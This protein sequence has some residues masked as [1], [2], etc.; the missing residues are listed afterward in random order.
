VPLHGSIPFEEQTRALRPADRRKVILATNIAETSL[1][2]EGVR[3]VIDSGRAR[4][5]GYDPQRGLDRLELKWISKA[6]PPSAPV[7]RGARRRAAH[8]TVDRAASS[9]ARRV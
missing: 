9:F 8:S 3:T 2:I 4:V 7:V 5:A 1:T 6:S